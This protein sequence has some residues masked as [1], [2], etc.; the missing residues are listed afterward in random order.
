M[1]PSSSTQ[2]LTRPVWFNSSRRRHRA[3]TEHA[4]LT[5]FRKASEC[6]RFGAAFRPVAGS[7]ACSHRPRGFNQAAERAEAHRS[8]WSIDQADQCS[9]LS[10]GLRGRKQSEEDFLITVRSNLRGETPLSAAFC[11][12]HLLVCSHSITRLTLTFIQTAIHG[13]V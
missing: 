2:I 5:A 8:N 10:P 7:R 1:G 6:F 3:V 4:D 13:S 12:V 11:H 9:C